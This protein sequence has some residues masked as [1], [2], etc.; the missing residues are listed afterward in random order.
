[1]N[2]VPQF[3]ARVLDTHIGLA[4]GHFEDLW[5]IADDRPILDHLQTPAHKLDGLHHLLHTH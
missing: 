1:M 3:P 2:I 4:R 5:N